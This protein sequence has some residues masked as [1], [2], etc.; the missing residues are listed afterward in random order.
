MKGTIRVDHYTQAET[1]VRLSIADSSKH[2]RVTALVITPIQEPRQSLMPQT[3]PSWLRRW[4]I[5]AALAQRLLA[6]TSILLQAMS[7]GMTTA[8][9]QY[10]CLRILSGV[11]ETSHFVAVQE[12]IRQDKVAKKKAIA[13]SKCDHY[14]PVTKKMAYT[15]HGNAYGKFRRCSICQMRWKE[16]DGEWA[17]WPDGSSASSSRSPPLSSAATTA[18][19]R[20]SSANKSTK[21]EAKVLEETIST[22]VKQEVEAILM[23][24]AFNPATGAAQSGAALP[25]PTVPSSVDDMSDIEVDT[26]DWF[27]PTSQDEAEEQESR[28]WIHND[29]RTARNWP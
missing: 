15:R 4:R 17:E 20:V 22:K 24:Q 16:I 26:E 9:L 7:I 19:P 18:G 6:N 27:Q 5:I 25:V 11:G 8:R 2:T 29:I 21:S 28:E 1:V 12:S 23:R 13:D 14:D 3:P 10:K